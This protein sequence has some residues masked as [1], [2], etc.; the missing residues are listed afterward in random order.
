MVPVPFDATASYGTGSAGA[1]AAILEA[2]HQVDLFDHETGHPYREG[3]AMDPIPS[4]VTNWN[5]EARAAARPILDR[6]G[7]I[8]GDSA[9]TESLA[10]V[11]RISEQ[12]NEHVYTRTAT[13]LAAGQLPVVLG[14]DHSAPFGAIQA[15]SEAYPEL[16]ILHFDAH[17]DLRQAYQGFVWSHASIMFN[18]MTRLPAVTRLV[19]VGLRDLGQA[20]DRMIQTSEG[21]IQA[22][23]DADLASALARG[24]RLDEQVAKMLAPLPA[25]VYVSIDIDALDP[26]LCPGT[27]TPVPGGLSWHQATFLLGELARSGRRIVG[28]DLCEVA[29][30]PLGEWDANVGARLLYKLIGF[31]A[32]SVFR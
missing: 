24:E 6:G 29:P 28:A 20:E 4:Q 9:L 10:Q 18:V 1:P 22:H 11:N 5:E 31:A 26:S 14:V 8:A 19:Q 23:F 2:S 16:G 30:G 21:R 32:L 13:L 25:S 15:C 3:I 27:G 17:A 7:K 12:V